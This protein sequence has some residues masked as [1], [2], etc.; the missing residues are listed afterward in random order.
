MQYRKDIDGLRAL[1]VGSVV[2]FHAGIPGFS[3][4]FVGVDIF[5]V[6]SG[7]LIT[8]I[9]KDSIDDGRFSF[10]DF[11]D[12]RIRRI[13]PALFAMYA[14]TFVVGLIFL[15]PDE[16]DALAES[17][18][19]SAVFFTNIHF[20]DLAGYFDT[21]STAKPLLHTWSLSV[22]EQFYII[23]PIAI[24]GMVR[25]VRPQRWLWMLS[26][27]ILISLGYAEWEIANENEVSSFFMLHARAWELMSGALLVYLPLNIALNRKLREL[28]SSLGLALIAGSIYF[29]S[30]NKDFPGVNAIFP[31]L[32]AVLVIVAGAQGQ[33]IVS[34]LLGIKP[35][36]FVGL[37]SYSLYLWHWPLFSYWHLLME[38]GPALGEA[39]VLICASMMLAVLS[40]HFIEKP[41]RRKGQL[42][43]ININKTIRA[44]LASIGVA[45]A[46][47]YTVAMLDGLPNRY[48]EDVAAVYK[49]FVANFDDIPNSNIKCK[50]KKLHDCL[51]GTPKKKAEVL[52]I[53]DSHAS[54]FALA[55][56]GVL[57]MNNLSGQILANSGCTFLLGMRVYYEGKGRRKCIVFNDL[58][59]NHIRQDKDAKIIVIAARWETHTQAE[60]NKKP[61]RLVDEIGPLPGQSSEN[62]VV[63]ERSIRRTIDY[64]IK[65]G[66]KVLL[67]GQVPINPKSPNSCVGKALYRGENEKDCFP[68][69]AYVEDNIGYG[70]NL[71]LKI[72][73]D[74]EDVDAFMPS[75]ILC[76]SE[77][78]SLFLNGEY[79][80]R[81]DDHINNIGSQQFAE[82]IARS[83]IFSN[84]SIS[85]S[86]STSNGGR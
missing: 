34:R 32:G 57:R 9:I 17:L 52:L 44:G 66:K 4:G 61:Y 25:F 22:E 68:S 78:C 58:A 10:A 49:N 86:H 12:R 5:F 77:R 33:T 64:L 73:D 62:R 71:L 83:P 42:L 31:C 26:G 18:V 29:L 69:T 85:V 41:F 50:S 36:V 45:V 3:G 53:G 43:S 38:R 39:F 14:A 40:W 80:Y 81:D 24:L 2:L 20:H 76:R 82:L 11:Y 46:V 30:E 37:I 1:A 7:Y 8:R 55:I 60:V 51:M 56:D 74:Y 16:L 72:S 65:N 6:I 84:S 59:S 54:H 48:N 35:L 75:K 23:W 47:A 13:F 70:N 63:L 27:G 19:S 21:A 79:L 67:M 28:M 15:M